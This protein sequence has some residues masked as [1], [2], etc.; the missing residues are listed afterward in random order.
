LKL[1][2][3]FKSSLSVAIT[4]SLLAAFTSLFISTQFES[5]HASSFKDIPLSKNAKLIDCSG[6]E[7]LEVHEYVWDHFCDGLVPYAGGD[8]KNLLFGYLDKDGKVAI[9]PQFYE[10]NPFSEGRAIARSTNG[11]HLIIDKEGHVV[12]QFSDKEVSQIS[13]YKNGFANFQPYN[14]GTTTG[15]LDKNGSVVV[16]PEF[17][18]IG[19]FCEGLAPAREKN[20]RCWGFIDTKGNW[21]LKPTFSEVGGFNI[22]IAVAVLNEQMG[23]INFKG[24]WIVA[25]KF[26]TLQN[27]K[28]GF[29]AVK[30]GS[31]WGFIDKT[32]N[33]VIPPKFDFVMEGFEG[34]LATCA[35][36]S[37]SL[38]CTNVKV[39]KE[40]YGYDKKYVVV[41]SSLVENFAL[42]SGDFLRPKL[43]FGLINIAGDWVVDPVYDN[44]Q[45]LEGGMR[46]VCLDGKYGYLDA[47]GKRI[48][49]PK[50]ADAKQFSDGVALVSMQKLLRSNQLLEVDESLAPTNRD[51]V[52]S[53]TPSAL[54]DFD[55]LENCLTECNQAALLKPNNATIYSDMGWYNYALNRN[56]EAIRCYEKGL[57]LKPKYEDLYLRRGEVFLRLGKWKEAENDFSKCL[58][59]KSEGKYFS[60]SDRLQW[61][62]GF[63]YLGEGEWAKAKAAFLKKGGSDFQ[64]ALLNVDLNTAT[65]FQAELITLCENVGDTKAAEYLLSRSLNSSPDVFYLNG[66]IF[67]YPETTAS[68]LETDKSYEEILKRLLSDK[69]ASNY[70]K[71]KAL[72]FAINSKRNL[73][74]RL[75]KERSFQKAQAVLERQ[76]GLFKTLRV[77]ANLIDAIREEH[78]AKL[79]L[80]DLYAMQND[81]RCLQ[82]FQ[83]VHDHKFGGGWA[84]IAACKYGEYEFLRGDKTIAERLLKSADTFSTSTAVQL[85]LDK[86]AR[87]KGKPLIDHVNFRRATG[88]SL[89]NRSTERLIGPMP[90]GDE[91]ARGY[92]DLAKVAV[93]EGFETSA[94]RYCELASKSA[95]AKL[96]KE[97]DIFMKTR[98][99]PHKIAY[100]PM[101]RF[102]NAFQ[103]NEY[104][105]PPSESA[106]ETCKICIDEEPSYLAPYVSLARIFRSEGAYADAQKYL[107]KA[108]SQNPDYLTAL[109]EKKILDSEMSMLSVK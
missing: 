5:A 2:I 65:V 36:N 92:F 16:K 80:A 107:E 64:N 29:A 94:R 77:Y 54:I 95:D 109:E 7:I 87:L 73:S 105:N 61:L 100:K 42:N 43:K 34:G 49:E 67:T 70:E 104:Y 57:A 91:D 63:C 19:Y 50:Y 24:D 17:S 45:P 13:D 93:A 51:D 69:S 4:S 108:L 71:E 28:N 53:Q 72:V 86:F 58:A 99:S 25:P 88:G 75:V 89:P 46:M 38:P 1:R 22:G 26:E 59:L 85:A 11:D 83:E 30:V 103:I 15:C 76:L 21:I 68:L 8:E 37:N 32:G 102:L 47:T 40:D 55:Y 27:F 41:E 52:L 62:L 84:T 48:V 60:I 98:L 81:K 82:L 35:L 3:G 97:I 10:A 14:Q 39:F 106:K 79:R 18:R 23:L 44:I 56:E 96:Q 101:A 12:K 6:K 74:F 33:E 66:A 20:G 90:I 31:K 78:V 9:K